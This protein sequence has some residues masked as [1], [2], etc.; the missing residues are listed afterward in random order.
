MNYSELKEKAKELGLPYFGIGKTELEEFV[1]KKLAENGEQPVIPDANEELK[2]PETPEI[3]E[4]P[5]EPEVPEQPKEP[6]EPEV[7]EESEVT[8]VNVAIVN[9]NNGY[10][11][12]RYTQEIHGDKFKEL[13]NQFANHNQYKVKLVNIK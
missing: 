2:S 3:P 1:N 6:K 5:K 12:R 13:A 8:D 11:V 10:E 9:N 7:P 4:T